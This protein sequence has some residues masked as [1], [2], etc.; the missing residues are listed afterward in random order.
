M[1]LILLI[2]SPAVGK[3]AV[4]CEL[5]KLTG[6]R[7]FINHDTIELLLKFFEYGD[8][9]FSKLDRL[10][11][12]SIFEEVAAS[13]LPGLIFTYVTALNEKH[14]HAEKKYLEEISHIF[15]SQ[16]QSVYFVEL[17]A[18]LKERLRRNKCASRI[19]AKPSKSNI[20]ESEKRLLEM[21]DKYIMNSSAEHPFH[22]A[23]NYVKI[24]TTNLSAA[25]VA[26]RI[27][28]HLKLTRFLK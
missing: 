17:E 13:A 27:Q 19:K 24:E 12:M 23:K 18:S 2:G 26:H 7:L 28:T 1:V 21:E 14:R 25:E 11:R 5:A 16:Y 10:F 22:L 8:P 3:M 4:G 6:L 15:T 9:H 20:H